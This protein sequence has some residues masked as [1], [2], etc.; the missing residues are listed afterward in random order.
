MNS[1]IFAILILL[2]IALV[3]WSLGSECLTA[4]RAD[5]L[6]LDPLTP[7]FNWATLATLKLRYRPDIYYHWAFIVGFS[8]LGVLFI[9][10]LFGRR[11]ALWGFLYFITIT[12]AM[13]GEMYALNRKPSYT[14]YLHLASLVAAVLCFIS[15]RLSKKSSP[16]VAWIDPAKS[17]SRASFFELAALLAILTIVF[18]TRFYALNRNPGTWDAEACGHRPV[19]ASWTKIAEQELGGHLQQSSGLTW[20]ALRKLFTRVDHPTEHYLDERIL[21]AIISLLT[22]WAVFFAVR[23][24]SGVFAAFLALIVYAFGP[25]DIDWARLPT[26]HHLPV[27]IGILLT[28]SSFVAFSSRSWSAFATTSVLILLCKFAYPSVKLA[29]LGPLMGL[30]GAI[31]WHRREWLGSKRKLSLI[32]LG[33]AA[34]FLFRPALY[35][36]MNGNYRWL[37]PVPMIQAVHSATSPLEIIQKYSWQSF[38]FLYEIFYFPFEPTHWTVHATLEPLRSIPS[39]AVIFVTLACVRMIFSPRDLYALISIGLIVGGLIPGLATGLSERRVGFSVILLTLLAIIEAAWFINTLISPTSRRF[40]NLAKAISLASI[41]AVL[42]TL[43][44]ASFFTRAQGKNVQLL[45]A[46]V[47]RPKLKDGT[48]VAYLAGERRCEFFY[49]IYDLLK[50]S[51]GKI[52]FTDAYDSLSGEAGVVRQPKPFT[53]GWHYTETDLKGQIE[54]VNQTPSWDRVLFVFQETPERKPLIDQIKAAYPNGHAE[55]IELGDV[56]QQ[57]LFIFDSNP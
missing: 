38:G 24:F 37:P 50:N 3:S 36:L 39:I 7:I 6:C 20:V 42:L 47:T 55:S 30:C 17:P 31:I 53:R 8:G 46:Q 1:R 33:L 2:F 16:T 18:C 15:M 35:A 29:F 27:L 45:T 10:Y 56:Q 26:M 44:T 14:L 48:L 11:Y 54:V 52:A 32:C 57:T 12:L 28:W 5:R 22:C 43:Q 4:E 41:A 9:A 51:N 34:F 21:G 19:A 40:A 49:S 13:C 25:I 23:R